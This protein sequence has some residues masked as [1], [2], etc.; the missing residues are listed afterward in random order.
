MIARLE[1]EHEPARATRQWL[2]GLQGRVK[3]VDVVASL[4]QTRPMLAIADIS[5]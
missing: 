4:G 5:L 3:L 1:A 2:Q